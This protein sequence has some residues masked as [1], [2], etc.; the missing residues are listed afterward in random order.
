MHYEVG[1]SFGLHIHAIM[2]SQFYRMLSEPF[3]IAKH[4][5][6]LVDN[7]NIDRHILK[8]TGFSNSSGHW[9]YACR[10]QPSLFDRPVTANSVDGMDAG[11]FIYNQVNVAA[12]YLVM[13]KDGWINQMRVPEH[14]LQSFWRRFG[15]KMDQ[16]PLRHQLCWTE[17]CGLLMD[18]TTLNA[19]HLC[20]I[21]EC[22][23][24]RHI[25]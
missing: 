13:W 5:Q 1:H 3:S 11:I 15:Q 6:K 2:C 7:S 17:Y 14:V 10:F 24:C 16:L 4:L 8:I 9:S 22:P 20:L 19:G 12:G 21:A 23:V 18:F 25:D